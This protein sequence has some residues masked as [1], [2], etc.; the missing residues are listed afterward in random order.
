MPYRNV[1]S[2]SVEAPVPGATAVRVAGELSGTTGA[3]LLRLLDNLLGRGP[4][5][6]G[7]APDGIPPRLIV[8]LSSVG[9]FERTGIDVLRHARH[10]AG[11][12]GVDFQ[13]TGIDDRRPLLPRRVEH[14]LEWLDTRPTLEDALADLDRSPVL[15]E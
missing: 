3:N 13:V 2:L 14:A 11:E 9:S 8:D 6:D 12:L 5:A 7:P 4:A 1:I 10:R 15:A